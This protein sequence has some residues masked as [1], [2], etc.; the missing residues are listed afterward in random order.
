[1]W[2]HCA[3][4]WSEWSG[5]VRTQTTLIISGSSLVFLKSNFYEELQRLLNSSLQEANLLSHYHQE[6]METHLSK[7]NENPLL[8]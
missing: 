4:L 7:D 2:L 6:S 3:V 5:K 8:I 1:M